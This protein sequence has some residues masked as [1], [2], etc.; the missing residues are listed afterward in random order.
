[1]LQIWCGDQEETYAVLAEDLSWVLST[2]VIGQLTATVPPT[3]RGS[4][5]S[6]LHELKSCTQTA[7]H[8]TQDPN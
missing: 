1:M 6:G 3:P 4:Q 7:T 8:N 2:H 5:A